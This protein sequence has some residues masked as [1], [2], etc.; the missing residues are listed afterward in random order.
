M[1]KFGEG[2]DR[3]IVNELGKEGRNVNSWHWT[4]KDVLLWSKEKLG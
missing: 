1:A 4:E 2:D 3:W